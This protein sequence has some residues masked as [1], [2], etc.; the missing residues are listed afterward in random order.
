MFAGHLGISRTVCGLLDR[1]YWPGLREYVQWAAVDREGTSSVFSPIAHIPSTESSGIPTTDSMASVTADCDVRLL[2]SLLTRSSFRSMSHDSESTLYSA[3]D[4]LAR[5][6]P[7]GCS[8]PIPEWR[9]GPFMAPMPHPRIGDSSD[10]CAFR[11]TTYQNSDFA[12]TL[13]KFGLPLHHPRFLEWVGASES[14]RLLDMG[15]GFGTRSLSRA[16]SVDAARQLHQDVCLMTSNLNILEYVLCLQGTA[17]KLLEL[18]WGRPDFPS[19]AVD[20]WCPS[21][22][23]VECRYLLFCSDVNNTGAHSGFPEHLAVGRFISGHHSCWC[24]LMCMT[25]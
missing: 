10:G 5:P 17:T 16:Q 14:A 8:V 11:C 21:L 13:G 12:Q 22:D 15:P 23:S 25:S 4:S 19:A 24:N 18:T 3:M 6:T 7:A 20:A 2:A 1:V 9:E